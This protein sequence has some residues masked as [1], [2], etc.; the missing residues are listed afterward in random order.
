MPRIPLKTIIAWSV[1]VFLQILLAMF[2]APPWAI[3]VLV[4]CSLVGWA[5]FTASGQGEYIKADAQ[6]SNVDAAVLTD[7]AHATSRMATGAAEVSFFIDGLVSDIKHSGNECSQIVDASRD[8]A[9]ASSQVSNNLQAIS[10]TINQTANACHVADSRLQSSVGNINQLAS[11]VGI[12]ADQLAQLRSSADNIQR[13]TEVINNLA[14]QTNLL[15]LNAAIEAARAGEQGRGFAVV[16][17]EVRALAGK[18]AEATADI[19]KMLAGIRDLS[20]KAS[21]SMAQLQQ[22]SVLVKDELNQVA[23]GFNEVNSDISHSSSALQQIENACGGIEITSS[24]ISQSISV[25]NQS[26]VSIEDRTK[27]IGERSLNVS[28]ETEAI[29]FGLSK[30][31]VELFYMPILREAQQAA[32]SIQSLFEQAISDGRITQSALFSE[33]YEPISNTN[34]QKYHTSFDRFTDE[35]LPAIQEPILAR[36]SLVLFAGAVDRLG[37]FPTHNKK[38]SQPLTGTY[39][40]DLINNRT[41]R[42]FKDRT[43]QRCGANTLPMLLQTYKR[44]TNEIIHDLSVPIFVQGRHW[45]G[46]RIG[47]IRP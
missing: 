15:A 11:S 26:F 33:H 2:A 17:D 19:G 13:I 43:G 46:F 39:A 25:I 34:P 31:S 21:G 10:K 18:T 40:V 27:S 20:Q 9:E 23:S 37:Y 3:I 16:A 32:Q 30:Q 1:L 7:I 35:H 41:K 24:R 5:L 36:H 44:D 4:S 45:G 29:Y 28:V 38:Y 6:L 14:G 8:L 12:A 47:F 22:S 42:I